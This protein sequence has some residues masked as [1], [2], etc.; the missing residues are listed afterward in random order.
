[1]LYC[2]LIMSDYYQEKWD[3][4]T[5]KNVICL[6]H[7]YDSDFRSSLE[8]NVNNVKNIFIIQHYHSDFHSTLE[9]NL[10]KAKNI[11]TENIWTFLTK[12]IN[13]LLENIAVLENYVVLG[14]CSVKTL[15]GFYKRT[16]KF[17]DLYA[18]CGIDDT[19]LTDNPFNT[20]LYVI[21]THQHYSVMKVTLEYVS[22]L[23]SKMW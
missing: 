4:G 19:L 3:K 21:Q 16:F 10:N 23:L 17:S 1:M 13:I 7:S 11:T 18:L 22:I 5:Q 6:Y 9:I 15:P 20:T 12:R 8:I 2:I 14:H